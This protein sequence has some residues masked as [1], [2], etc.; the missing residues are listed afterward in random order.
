M[1]VKPEMLEFRMTNGEVQPVVERKKVLILGATGSVGSKAVDVIAANHDKFHGHTLIAMGNNVEQLAAQAVRLSSVNVAVYDT[2]SAYQL[3]SLLHSSNISVYCGPEAI[4]DLIHN[5][6][7]ITVAAISGIAGLTPIMHAI[8]YSKVVAIAN[9]ESVVCAQH[10][11]LQHAL[12]HGTKILPIDSEHSAIFQ[13]LHCTAE[14]VTYDD[15]STHRCALYSPIIA[16][17]SVERITLTA[18]G[19]PFLNYTSRQMEDV[20]PEQACHHPTWKMGRKIS[21]DSATLMNK[22]LEIIE[23]SQFFAMALDKIDVVIHPESIIHGM[24]KNVD[25][26]ILAHCSA[27]DMQIAIAFALSYPERLRLECGEL[28]FTKYGTCSFLKP[29]STKFPALRIVRDAAYAGQAH[30]IAMNAAN[31]CA[32]AA[33]LAGKIKFTKITNTVEE[34]ITKCTAGQVNSI[35]D[36][37]GIHAQT[38]EHVKAVLARYR[39]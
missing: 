34:G 11:L 25:G 15:D 32:V 37:L 16:S 10:I 23:A 28:D 36:V 6:F 2:H 21:V 26:S 5:A 12:L 35:E 9:K 31:E 19:G 33:F 13:L 30:V 20:T 7:D 27:H 17:R 18:S 24:I 1:N 39:L 8:P 14:C 38:T 4:L 22:A 29:D 3:R